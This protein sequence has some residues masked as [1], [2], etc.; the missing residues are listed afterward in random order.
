MSLALFWSSGKD[1][2][3]A[4]H[5][6]RQQGVDV[7]ALITTFAAATGR[8]TSHGVRRSVVRRQAAQVDLPLIEVDLPWPC[9][10][11]MYQFAVGATLLDLKRREGITGV[12]SGDLFLADVRD[13]RRRLAARHGLSAE[14]PL[15]GIRSDLLARRMLR[16][17]VEAWITSVDAARTDRTLV[18]A[19]WSEEL[20][21][22]LPSE[23]DPCGERGE[24]HTLITGGPM[25]A[26][27]I[28]V[29]RIAD[30]EVDGMPAAD[31]DV[32]IPAAR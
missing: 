7:A 10:N 31:F 1:A 15:W 5:L 8:V 21:R 14:F 11:E 16:A 18:G 20:L 6:L 28:R 23:V 26:A 19:R 2:A 9:S 17:G 4:L 12:A 27:P 25:F 13:F 24:F 30:L 22:A 29:D 3:W 32:A